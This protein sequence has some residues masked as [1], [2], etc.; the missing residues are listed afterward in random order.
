MII[1]DLYKEN[2]VQTTDSQGVVHEWRRQKRQTHFCHTRRAL[3][4]Q[5][6]HDATC[7]ANVVCKTPTTESTSKTQGEV[8]RASDY[9]KG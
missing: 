3:L 5:R 9:S 8:L 6:K 2:F 7:D 4:G 1:H